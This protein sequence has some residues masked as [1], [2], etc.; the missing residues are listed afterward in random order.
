MLARH[1]AH[2][3]VRYI[4]LLIAIIIIFLSSAV[5]LTRLYQQEK[6]IVTD[7]R[8]IAIQQHKNSED[9]V[10]AAALLN[11]Q[12]DI[13][14]EYLDYLFRTFNLNLHNPYVIRP[15]FEE[16]RC[17]H[18][19]YPE[20]AGHD[21]DCAWL[22]CYPITSVLY[23]A[24]VKHVEPSTVADVDGNI[25]LPAQPDDDEPALDTPLQAIMENGV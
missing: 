13:R 12:A 7:L 16:K 23:P 25:L 2:F 9:L 21:K 4:M 17:Y 20:Y 18:C 1:P 5:T 19:H 11:E 10:A 15:S 22:H 6:K 3:V 14:N 24:P 8:R